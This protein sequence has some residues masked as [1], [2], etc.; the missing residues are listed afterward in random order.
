MSK[1][2]KRSPC[3]C[4]GTLSPCYQG[5]SRS[6]SF[7]GGTLSPRFRGGTLSPRFR[8][9]T[10]SPRF[11]GGTLSPRMKSCEI[12]S[13]ERGLISDNLPAKK[14][15][16]GGVQTNGKGGKSRVKSQ[17]HDA[18]NGGLLLW[19]AYK[20]LKNDDVKTADGVPQPSMQ[21]EAPHL[22]QNSSNKSPSLRASV[23]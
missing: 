7:R 21:P 3:Y 2:P 19:A 11:Q 14:G 5:G 20:M 1:F 18:Q 13:I 12:E 22:Q 16:Q 17:T 23:S 8:G 10:L 6:P 4:G 9:G 15:Q